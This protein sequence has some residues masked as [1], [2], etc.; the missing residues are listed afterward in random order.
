MS[1]PEPVVAREN[2]P[3]SHEEGKESPALIWVMPDTAVTHRF[4]FI[5]V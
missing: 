1:N 2:F 3:R 5:P 4:P